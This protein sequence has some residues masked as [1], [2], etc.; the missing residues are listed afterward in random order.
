MLLTEKKP[1][2]QVTRRRVPHHQLLLVVLS[3]LHGTPAVSRESG[4][5]IKLGPATTRPDFTRFG[6]YLKKRNYTGVGAQT[7]FEG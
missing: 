2:A 1:A 4:D 5:D 3:I 7:D 6:T